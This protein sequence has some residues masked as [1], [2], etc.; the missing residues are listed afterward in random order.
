M[1]KFALALLVSS[2]VFAATPPMMPMDRDHKIGIQNSI[3]TQVN[4]NTISVMD[5]KKKLDVAF[6]HA[7]PSLADS[8][9]ARFQFYQNSWRHA[10][11]EMID[12]ELI[13]ADAEEKEI[14]VTEGEV[15]EEVENRFGPNVLKT[16]DK[17]GLTYDEAWKM[18]KSEMLVQRMVWYFIQ[19]KAIQSVTPQDLRQAYRLYI[20]E[21]PSYQEWKY[22]VISIRGD[23]PESIQN[24]SQ[25]LHNILV[26]S[27]LNPDAIQSKLKEFESTHPSCTIQVSNEYKAKDQELSEAHRNALAAILP[28]QYGA[29]SIQT[30]RKE[31]KTIS[32]IFYLA[33]KVDHPAPS[34]DEMAQTLK[35]DLIQKAMASEST[36]Y[37]TKLR[38]HYGY[39]ADHL[40]QSVPDNLTPFSLQ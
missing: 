29:P 27:G 36:H 40:K 32:R 10:F 20:K 22:R 7:Y 13:L 2:S 21:N 31:K 3:L 5:V 28:G 34:F 4:G 18:V 33:D 39:D 14:K 9:A 8:N 15:R 23:S 25:E 35:N 37:I 30:S 6:H 38:K 26:E 19:S 12:N 17:I 24:L 1:K 11:M 16:L